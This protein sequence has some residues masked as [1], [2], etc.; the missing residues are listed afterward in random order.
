MKFSDF[1]HMR[2]LNF[3]GGGRTCVSFYV[4]SPRYG[5]PIMSKFA[6]HN[7]LRVARVQA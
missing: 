5:F 1:I 7:E 6:P 2:D 3:F 4:K